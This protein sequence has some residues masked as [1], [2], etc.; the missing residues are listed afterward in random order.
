[1]NS[2]SDRS[3]T[4][5]QELLGPVSVD[6][7][8]ITLSRL[9]E[10]FVLNSLLDLLNILTVSIAISLPASP[11]PAFPVRLY[12]ALHRS[13]ILM[14]QAWL[15]TS[16]VTWLLLIQIFWGGLFVFWKNFPWRSLL[17]F[18][19]LAVPA[20][21]CNQS[22]SCGEAVGEKAPQNLFMTTKA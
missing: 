6:S 21:L 3:N 10:P 12:A 17:P 19:R 20:C 9:S 7:E 22:I 8:W 2:A 1:M 5:S 11:F 15:P 16:V 13:A 4:C 14:P 18:A